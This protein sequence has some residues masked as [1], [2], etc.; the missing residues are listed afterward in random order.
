MRPI[1]SYFGWT[2]GSDSK[3]STPT[4]TP[5]RRVSQR[6]LWDAA[7]P[8]DERQLSPFRGLDGMQECFWIEDNLRH[9]GRQLDTCSAKL[10]RMSDSAIHIR[11]E[12]ED[13]QK[14]LA[15]IRTRGG[16]GARR[17]VQ[18][19]AP[20]DLDEKLTPNSPLP[21]QE[22]IESTSPQSIQFQDISSES[23]SYTTASIQTVDDREMI[24]EEKA[25]VAQHA[26]EYVNIFPDILGSIE[27]ESLPQ[28]DAGEEDYDDLTAPDVPVE[29]AVTEE[30]VAEEAGLKKDK[31]EENSRQTC[32]SV[33]STALQGA[34]ALQDAEATPKETDQPQTPR[35]VQSSPSEQNLAPQTA[36]ALKMDDEEHRRTPRSLRSNPVQKRFPFAAAGNS[37]AG[38]SRAG[39]PITSNR[40]SLKPVIGQ[41]KVS[42]MTQFWS[43]KMGT[44]LDG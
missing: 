31:K 33:E 34:D 30:V 41:K 1:G 26:P 21:G 20:K 12:L 7:S 3:T 11:K 5:S 42:Q 44:P 37:A 27:E 15:S 36:A 8:T 14:I 39:H 6:V 32:E 24:T 10:H 17:D 23:A 22:K 40:A 18:D 35:P 13:L 38:A 4:D 43:Q 16:S 25:S 29:E 9:T 2:R 28:Q 19:T